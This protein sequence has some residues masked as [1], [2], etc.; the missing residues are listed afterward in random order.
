M[1]LGLCF[2]GKDGYLSIFSRNH[3][4]IRVSET[5]DS[6]CVVRFTRDSPVGSGPIESRENKAGKIERNHGLMD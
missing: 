6:W 3:A 1:L 2:A 4:E 5:Q